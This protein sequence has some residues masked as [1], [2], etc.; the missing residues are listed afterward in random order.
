MELKQLLEQF[1]A[2]STD[3]RDALDK[4]QSE[5]RENGQASEKTGKE[6]QAINNRL[7]QIAAEIKAA[8]TRIESAET[9]FAR[10]GFRGGRQEEPSTPGQVFTESDTYKNAVRNGAERTD[11]VSVPSFWTPRNTLLT[12]D[13]ASGGGLI[14]PQRV[15]GVVGIPEMGLRIRDLMN[16]RPT[17][18]NLIQYV[19]ETGF[20]NAAAPR[21]EGTEKPESALSYLLKSAPAEVIAHWLPATR[22][23][24]A[25]APQMRDLID[26]RLTYGLKVEEEAQILYGSGV[27][28]NLQGIATHDDV[29]TYSWSAGLITDNQIDAIRRAMALGRVAGYP[30]TGIVMHPNDW[31]DIELLKG[32]D[33]HYLWVTVTTGGEARLWRVPVV[34][35]DAV[36]EGEPIVGA[37]RLGATL[38]DREEANVRLSDSHGD[39]FIKNKVAVLAEERVALTIYRPEAFVVVTLDGAPVS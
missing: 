33:G 17:D 32:E 8:Q 15:A 36:T 38:W 29:Q 39:F 19:Q 27:S 11:I 18:S 23:I 35:S 13:P 22:Q 37:W 5:I 4:Q 3:I 30:A 2:T 14:A 28:P 1:N 7:D 20:T 6:V 21:A 34:E 12:S 31:A 24:V 10:N 16:V 25:D 26:T 9:E